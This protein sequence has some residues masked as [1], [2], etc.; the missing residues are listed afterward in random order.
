MQVHR[1]LIV[2]DVAEVRQTVGAYLRQRGMEVFYAENGDVAL[3]AARRV[4]PDVIVTD[5][6]MPVMD[7]LEMCRRL[8][9]DPAT[10]DLVVV[11]V[12][13]EDV[14]DEAFKAGCDAVLQKPCSGQLLMSTIESLTAEKKI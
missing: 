5:V 14:A 1:V 2:D 8:R 7:G 12:T 13:G 10:G 6:D 9:A 4:A 11:A 3:E